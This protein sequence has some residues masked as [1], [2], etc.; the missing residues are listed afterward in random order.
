MSSKQE[1]CIFGFVMCYVVVVV[2][3][4]K[5]NLCSIFDDHNQYGY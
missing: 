4:F 5:W 2:C 3:V 1:A